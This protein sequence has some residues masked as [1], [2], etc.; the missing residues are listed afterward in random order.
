MVAKAVKWMKKSRSSRPEVFCTKGFLKI[1]QNSQE[2]TCAGSFLNRV[3][4]L[5]PVTLLKRDSN[6]G[7]FIWILWNENTYYVKLLW[8]AAFETHVYLN[9]IEQ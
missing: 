2:N 7:A 3:T 4:G 5:R 9:S 6:V 1:S 8:A